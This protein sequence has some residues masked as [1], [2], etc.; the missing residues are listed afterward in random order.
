MWKLTL[1]QIWNNR[2]FNF[3]IFIEIMIVSVLLWYCVDFIYVAVKKNLEPMG[4]NTEHVYRLELG[5]N[6]T[7]SINRETQDS[8]ETQWINPFL[9][10]V[11]LVKEYPG[12][13][14]VAYFVGTEPFSEGGMIQAYTTDE[15]SRNIA[16]IRYVS[17]DYDKVFKVAMQGGGFNDWNIKTSP[18]GAVVSPELADSLFQSQSVIGKKFH[19]YYQPELTFRVTGVSAP[20]KFNIYDRYDQFIYTPFN[21]WRFAY[22]IPTIGIRISPEADK[23]GFEQQ[24]IEDMKGNLNIGPFY[25]F[26]LTSYDFKSDVYNA[27]SGVSNYLTVITS[28]LIVFLGI[29]GTFWFQMESRRSEIGLRMALGSSQKQILNKILSESLVIFLLAFIPALIICFSLA[30]WN[31]TYTFHD[32]MDY[33]WSRFWTTQIFTAIIIMGIISLGALIPA[34]RASKTHPVDA[35]RDE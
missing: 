22:H 25:L 14:A 13:E 8:V 26:S 23:V 31:V 35:L 11:R 12:V 20:M 5:S 18:Q 1:K 29:L 3:W 2:K 33:T 30:D 7:M 6:P 24:F 4:V 19:D 21:I 17:E 16:T 34:H 32:A 10:V 15:E 9:Q 27:V 28:L